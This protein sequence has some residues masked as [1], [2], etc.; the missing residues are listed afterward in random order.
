MGFRT[1]FSGV[2]GLGLAL[3]LVPLGCGGTQDDYTVIEHP[4]V[5]AE[6]ARS[7]ADELPEEIRRPLITC[8]QHHAGS[9]SGR[10]FAVRYDAK[11]NQDGVVQEVTLRNTTLPEGGLEGCLRQ[12][13]ATMTVPEQALRKRSSGPFSG[14]ERMTRER[15]GPLGDSESSNP[16]VLLGPIIVEAVSV[17]VI[18]EIAVGII[19]AIGTISRPPSLKD[20]CLDK[21]VQCIASP[22]GRIEVD[23]RG[24]TAC[25]SCQQQCLTEGSWPT[26][27][28]ITKRWQTCLW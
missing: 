17:E 26:G 8:I 19:A 14:G 5:A 28:M 16:L 3:G 4:S 9:W 24:T 1:V 22:L 11:A 10:S 21:Y 27:F 6:V 25:A 18:I 12:V 2:A 23:V 7:H 13:I 20:K 15:R